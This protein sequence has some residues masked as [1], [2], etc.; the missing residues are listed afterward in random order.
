MPKYKYAGVD[1]SGKKR[2]GTVDAVLVDDARIQLAERGLRSLEVKETQ[3]FWTFEVK[4]SKVKRIELI[5]FSRQ[6]A[7]FVRAG[8]PILD[9]IETLRSE[10]HNK[11]MRKVLDDVDEALRKG[12]TFSGAIAR[13]PEVFP[14]FYTAILRSAELTGQLDTVL[15]QLSVYLERDDATRRKIKSALTYPIVVICIAIVAVIVL[16]VFALPHFKTFFDSFDA[17]LPLV[18]RILLAI[19]DFLTEYGLILIAAVALIVALNVLFF[20][21]VRGRHI[22]DRMALR[23]PVL[24]GIIQ[25][26]M[27]ERFCR[28]VGAMVRAGVPAPEGMAVAA[29]SLSNVVYQEAIED[30]RDAMMQGEGMA[31]PISRTGM[32][33]GVA[34]QMIRVGEETGTLDAQLDTCAKYFGDEAEFRTERLTNML[35]PMV[36]VFVGV[37]VGFVAIALVSAMYGIYDQVQV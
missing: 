27:V 11:M 33:P 3:P 1:E 4:K 21:T 16:V 19:T 29:G 28:I 26:T 17:K 22:R 7:A 23:M 2:R 35:E 30:V 8:V 18:T 9:A 5:H 12:E 24:G 37:I 10:S 34:V 36:I 15:D 31:A 13:H 6:L 25:Y 14:S 32:F 20:R